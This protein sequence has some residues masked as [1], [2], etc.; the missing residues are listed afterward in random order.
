MDANRGRKHKQARLAGRANHHVHQKMTALVCGELPLPREAGR[1]PPGTIRSP[2]I[3]RGGG[4]AGA[5][6]GGR[7]LMADGI[8]LLFSRIKLRVSSG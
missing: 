3:M 5:A 1:G 8:R 6:G 2:V 7:G 4:C